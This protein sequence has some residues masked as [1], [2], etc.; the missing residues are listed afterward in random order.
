MKI[1]SKLVA[2]RLQKVLV[3]LIHPT[4]TGFIKGRLIG[5]NVLKI[6]NMID[7]CNANKKSAVLISFDFEKAFYKVSWSAI[8]AALQTFNF[9]EKFIELIQLMYSDPVSCVLNGGYTGEY[10]SLARSTRQGDPS[11]AL[12]FALVVEILGIKIR[13]N[14]T[15]KGIEIGNYEIL[16]AQY[17]DDL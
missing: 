10:F 8:Y 1:L 13:T 12:I 15:I 4:Q 16:T 17:A 11:S 7:Y 6:L 14:A 2:L 5:E 9:G 3:K